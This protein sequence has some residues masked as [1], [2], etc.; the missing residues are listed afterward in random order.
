L[1]EAADSSLRF[2][3]QI[4]MPVYGA[5]GIPEYWIADVERELLIVHRDPQ[6][7]GYKTVE[8]FQGDDLVS[9][10]AAPELKFAV[11]QAFD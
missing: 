1:I 5:A 3:R 7:D 11:R 8:R 9:P 10:L 2:D 6:A 4:K